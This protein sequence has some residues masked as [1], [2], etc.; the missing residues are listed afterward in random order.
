MEHTI[1]DSQHCISFQSGEQVPV[2]A[3]KGFPERVYPAAL[4]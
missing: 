1:P 4:N 2:L 3:L